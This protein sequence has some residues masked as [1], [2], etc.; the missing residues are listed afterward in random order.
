VGKRHS[1]I[2]NATKKLEKWPSIA[3]TKTVAMSLEVVECALAEA[4]EFDGAV[5]PLTLGPKDPCT[6]EDLCA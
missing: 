5:F 4:R 3:A 1:P 2:V 6:L